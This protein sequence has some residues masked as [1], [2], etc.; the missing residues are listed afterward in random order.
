M[1]VVNRFSRRY[2][3]RLVCDS[4]QEGG[5]LYFNSMNH[6][7]SCLIFFLIFKFW[8]FDIVFKNSVK[9]VVYQNERYNE[10][11]KIDW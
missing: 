6:D 2:Q 3:M 7:S 8:I 11:T 5:E 9:Q 4:Y 10:N 1:G